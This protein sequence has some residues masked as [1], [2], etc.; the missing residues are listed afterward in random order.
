MKIIQ[1][2]IEQVLLEQDK[3]FKTASESD[4]AIML[5]QR[6]A[7]YNCILYDTND[8]EALIHNQDFNSNA[9]VNPVV[10]YVSFLPNQHNKCHNGAE[11]LMS[12]ARKDSK[13]GIVAYESALY[14]ATQQ[15][16][17]LYADRSTPSGSALE[18]WKKY[19]ER[20]DVE[21]LR[22]DD[23][24]NPKTPP[25][26][27][28]CHLASK[29]KK[30]L[31]SFIDNVYRLKEKPSALSSLESSHEK[32]INS[33]VIKEEEFKKQMKTFASNLFNNVY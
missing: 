23:V 4:Y 19:S 24:E 31:S 12:A 10:A 30:R 22:F 11:V 3:Y 7:V 32:F 28:D 1:K 6:G 2:Y 16:G 33:G 29:G 8:V 26:N 21:H 15:F 18:V 13:M 27:D 17:G 5:F 9:V 25:P 14:Y 20:P